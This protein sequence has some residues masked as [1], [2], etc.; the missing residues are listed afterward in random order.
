[1][2]KIIFII[3]L[4]VC[5]FLYLVVINLSNN[6]RDILENSTNDQIIKSNALTMMYETDVGSGEYQLS[7]DSEWLGDEYIFNETLSK[8]ENGSTLTWDDENKKVLMQ[9]NTSDKCYVYF[10]KYNFVTIKSVDA[11]EITSDSITVS[12]NAIPG[13]G[14]IVSYHYSINEG[15]YIS[16][17]NNIYTF[18]NLEAETSYDISIYIID[19]NGR[20]ASYTKNGVITLNSPTILYVEIYET[21]PPSVVLNSYYLKNGDNIAFNVGDTL[22]IIPAL[23]IGSVSFYNKSDELVASLSI[24]SCNS[25]QYVLTGEE[26]KI[27]I[28]GYNFSGALVPEKCK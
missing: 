14:E 26:S 20:K 4:I 8:C 7:T 25:L 9:A 22:Q 16:S 5:F 15:E 2:K 10:D 21:S 1:M 17:T 28:Q 11:T 24:N 19:S 27:I 6:E 12:V 18:E 23:S 3:S 13:D